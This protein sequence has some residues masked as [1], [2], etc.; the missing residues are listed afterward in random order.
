[1]QIPVIFVTSSQD[2]SSKVTGFEVGGVDY[3]TKPYEREEVLARVRVHLRLR[4]AYDSMVQYHINQ[5]SQLITAQE[6]LLPTKLELQHANSSIAH[7]QLY[8]VAAITTMCSKLEM[9]CVTM[10]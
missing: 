9:R 6:A 7:K 4:Q 10:W 1:M 8:K 2:T 3:I 5:A